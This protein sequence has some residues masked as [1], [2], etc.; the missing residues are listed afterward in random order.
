MAVFEH[1]GIAG[2][3]IAVFDAGRFAPGIYFFIIKEMNSGKKSG[4][5]KFTIKK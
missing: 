1:A 3:N 4:A 2:K 5:E